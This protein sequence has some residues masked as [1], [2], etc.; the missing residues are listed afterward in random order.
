MTATALELMVAQGHFERQLALVSEHWTSVRRLWLGNSKFLDVRKLRSSLPDNFLQGVGMPG[1]ATIRS[2][3]DGRFVFTEN[4]LTALIIPA[5][6][7]IP[8]NVDANPIRH[9]EHLIDLVAVDL[10]RPDRFWRRRGEALVLG[11][12]YLEIARQERE[13]VP[14]FK[15]PLSWLQA[16]G[17]GIMVLDWDYARDL[18]RD[19]DLIAEDLGLGDRLEVTLRPDIWIRGAA[20]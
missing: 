13:P 4:G 9:L 2:A 17:A 20:A 14:V 12:A 18:L 16:G 6:D 5:Y 10:N 1:L 7:T 15:N 11:N 19:H 3:R 8:G